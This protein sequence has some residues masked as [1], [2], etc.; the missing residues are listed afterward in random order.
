MM[1]ELIESLAVP[2]SA[3]GCTKLCTLE[4][5]MKRRMN[6]ILAFFD[7]ENSAN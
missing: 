5:T 1:A 3:L 6:D 2:D 4:R 7:H